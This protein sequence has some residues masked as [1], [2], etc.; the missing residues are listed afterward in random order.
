MHG[1]APFGMGR[2]VKLPKFDA[3][4]TSDTYQAFDNHRIEV[5]DKDHTPICRHYD[6]FRLIDEN[7][8]IVCCGL[9]LT[10]NGSI[11]QDIFDMPY[12][13]MDKSH[14]IC[15]ATDKIWE[16]I[17]A[18]NQGR[19]SCPQCVQKY[20]KTSKNKD[21]DAF[22]EELKYMV[23]RGQSCAVDEP[24]ESEKKKLANLVSAIN[25]SPSNF[26]KAKAILEDIFS[27]TEYA[28]DWKEIA[29]QSYEFHHGSGELPPKP[30]PDV[31]PILNKLIPDQTIRCFWCGKVIVNR[32]GQ[33]IHGAR[34]GSHLVCKYC[35]RTT[36]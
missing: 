22:L 12:E 28:G 15:K 21:D 32:Y 11:Y 1:N 17:L 33:L 9:Y 27:N 18:Y 10:V 6:Q 25:E 13:M 8:K 2:A 35:K 34:D 3:Y 30:K 5:L 26:N 14:E 31:T 20:E 7:Q 23:L 24:T 16:S 4:D 19:I 36:F 29:K